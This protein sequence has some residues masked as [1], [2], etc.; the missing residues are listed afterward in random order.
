MNSL[1]TLLRSLPPVDSAESTL[2]QQ[3]FGAT[4]PVLEQVQVHSESDSSQMLGADAMHEQFGTDQS[5]VFLAHSSGLVRKVLLEK[6]RVLGKHLAEVNA[7]LVQ[8]HY[9][10]RNIIAGFEKSKSSLRVDE[11]RL[12]AL[13]SRN[14]RE[15]NGLDKRVTTTQTHEFNRAMAREKQESFRDQAKLMEERRKLAERYEHYKLSL[16]LFAGQV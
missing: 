1:T 13:S 3:P 11:W 12:E 14:I 15:P 16:S 8:R 5:S 6:V 7:Q 4:G 9:L 2:I 10:S